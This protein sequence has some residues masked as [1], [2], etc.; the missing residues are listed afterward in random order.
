[1]V[2]DCTPCN[3]FYE[4]RFSPGVLI[5]Q[6]QKINGI[7]GRQTGLRRKEITGWRQQGFGGAIGV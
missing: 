6:K 3:R 7:H 2:T 5:A 4:R 1:M